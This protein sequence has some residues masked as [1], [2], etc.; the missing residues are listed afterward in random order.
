M[1]SLAILL[2]LAVSTGRAPSTRFDQLVDGRVAVWGRPLRPVLAVMTDLVSPTGFAVGC[3][4]LCLICAAL[5][6][7]PAAAL[8]LVGPGVAV[9]TSDLVLKPV[10]ASPAAAGGFGFPSGHA[11]AVSAV[12]VLLALLTLPDGVL[13]GRLD[14]AVAWLVRLA[15]GLSVGYVALALIALRHHSATEVAG[16]LAVGLCA[17]CSAALALDRATRSPSG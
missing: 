7:W 12:A 17:V 16:G 4:C 14:G 5:R 9:V 8:A 1:G 13:S 11:T 2:L 15:A 3:L 10:I 6:E